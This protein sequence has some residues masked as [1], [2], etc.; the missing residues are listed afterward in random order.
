MRVRF[1]HSTVVLVVCI[2]L[3][4]SC[5]KDPPIPPKHTLPVVKLEIA[6]KYLWS[7]DSGIY[8]IGSN[9]INID[10]SK[11]I[12]ANYNQK[13]EFPA[14]ISYRPADTEIT[15][16]EHPVGVRIKGN[17]SRRKAMKTL[18]IYW[19]R[20]YGVSRLEYQIFGFYGADRFKRLQLRNSGNDYGFT[21]MKDG[22]VIEIIKD[23][24][25]VEYA[26]YKPVVLYLNDE[27]WGIHNMREMITPHHF[28]YHYG[29]DDDEVD[30]LGGSPLYPEV[31]DGSADEFIQGLMSAIETSDL[32]INEDYQAI[33]GLMDIDNFIDYIIIE[34]YVGN[35]DWPVTN[36]KWWKSDE[37]GGMG[38]KWRW[39]CMD[40]DACFEPASAL[41]VWIG[42]LYGEA[43]NEKK[44]EGF[45][46]FNELIKNKDFKERFLDRYL[47]FI[48]TVFE[49]ARVDSIISV[50]KTDLE[51]EYTRHQEKWKTLSW[52]EWE[53]AIHEVME[54]NRER[55]N[56]IKHIIS[57]L[58]E[59]R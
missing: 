23:F 59:N 36:M 8:V 16:F 5:S 18:G 55:N 35:R 42:D 6:E 30:L 49:P 21:Q 27:Y 28:D 34:T 37:I 32:S 40:H 56:L 1:T 45:Y 52:R 50:M 41:K 3:F 24:A 43:P 13:W 48:D 26:E 47:F 19:R 4:L 11:N 39:I 2:T 10:C 33:K 38:S 58:N 44:N 9:G 53:S 22:A 31:D 20:E 46:I 51:P 57:D 12:Q 14:T 15:V 7:A 17:C 54:I 25:N 29:V